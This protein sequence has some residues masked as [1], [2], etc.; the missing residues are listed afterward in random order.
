M[1]R[2]KWFCNSCNIWR[3][4]R[5][6]MWKTRELSKKKSITFSRCFREKPPESIDHKKSREK[7]TQ[8]LLRWKT[9]S[10]SGKKF[11][12]TD[13]SFAEI[14]NRTTLELKNQAN[15]TKNIM[16]YCL[17]KTSISLFSIMKQRVSELQEE[18]ANIKMF[19]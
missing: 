4:K 10:C 17:C 14:S 5:V 3:T 13:F 11:E 6:S 16:I 19:T 18:R 8:S 15:D 12:R 1:Q 2:V 9:C 7:I